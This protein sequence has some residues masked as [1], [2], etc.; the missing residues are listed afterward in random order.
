MYKHYMSPTLSVQKWIAI[1]A[2][3]LA[4]PSGIF[5]QTSV[6][7]AG[8]GSSLAGE[9]PG[10]QVWPQVSVNSLGGYVVWQDNALG[11]GWGIGAMRLNRDLSLVP[12]SPIRINRLT[13]GDREK[14]KAAMLN[15][16]S[17]IV[18]WQGPGKLGPD[19]FAG[20]IGA[21]GTVSKPDV[22]VNTFKTDAQSNPEVAALQ[23]GKTLPANTNWASVTITTNS[24]PDE[25]VAVAASY[26]ATLRY[27]AQTPFSDQLTFKWEGGMW[28]YDPYHNSIITAGNS[29]SI[30]TSISMDQVEIMSH[31]MR[32]KTGSGYISCSDGSDIIVKHNYAIQ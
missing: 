22:A 5:A 25:L 27:G 29:R 2:F 3:W 4:F 23:D 30:Y 6:A 13:V 10:D 20:F 28:E 15:N 19:I 31:F 1:S 14:P 16:G 12:G 9:L 32:E 21:N 11:G 17:A 8:G 24:K 7:P 26:D 18:V